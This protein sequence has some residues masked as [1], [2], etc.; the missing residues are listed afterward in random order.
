MM[1]VISDN[2]KIQKESAL[3]LPLSDTHTHTHTHTNTP[4]CTV[5]VEVHSTTT[6]GSLFSGCNT[7]TAVRLSLFTCAHVGA[8]VHTHIPGPVFWFP[9]C[10]IVACQSL[11]NGPLCICVS[12]CRLIRQP[13]WPHVTSSVSSAPLTLLST[14]DHPP[15]PSRLWGYVARDSA[16]TRTHVHTPTLNEYEYP[17]NLCGTRRLSSRAACICFGSSSCYWDGGVASSGLPSA[18]AP[19]QTH[20]G[21]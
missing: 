6:E 11:I 14:T 19:S 12:V 2:V 21:A 17:L 18:A 16:N 7:N 9:G 1:E 4:T 13:S 8:G 3:S 5:E 20:E 15:S 10:P